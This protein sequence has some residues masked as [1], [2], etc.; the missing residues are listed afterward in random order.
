[1]RLTRSTSTV[2]LAL[3]LMSIASAQTRGPSSSQVPYILPLAPGVQTVS[4]LTVGD[5]LN[6][7]DSLYRLV[8]IPD[9]LGVSALGPDRFELLV[10]HE[11]SGGSG[12]IHAHGADGAFVS[13]WVIRRSDLTVLEGS[14]LI[15]N[16]NH[17]TGTAQI[18]RLCSGDL[19]S[20]KAF[21]PGLGAAAPRIFMGGEEAGIQGRAF[22]H[23]ASGPEAGESFEL[24]ALGNLSFENIL[25]RPHESPR[26]VVAFMDDSSPG[27][28]YMYIGTKQAT[29]NAIARTPFQ[30]R[31]VLRLRRCQR[32]QRALGGVARRLQG[33]EG[34]VKKPAGNS[35]H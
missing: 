20:S 17:S 7:S 28:V 27:Q 8:G 31:Q 24:P 14:D 1:M 30:I 18:S 2:I 32:V 9:G 23:V 12:S 26:T 29:G 10:N 11:L 35:W 4:I 15:H 25:A 33:P 13:K 19:P 22:A 3:A 6:T 16:L 34:P 5:T 21:F